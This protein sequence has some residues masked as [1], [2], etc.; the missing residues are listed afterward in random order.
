MSLKEIKEKM[1]SGEIYDPGEKELLDYQ[2]TLIEKVNQYN[3]T[4]ATKQGLEER[5]KMS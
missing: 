3:K 4:P 5:E 2:I 1:H